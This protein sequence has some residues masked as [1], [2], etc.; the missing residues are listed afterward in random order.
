MKEKK[1]KLLLRTCSHS[2][3]TEQV[4][5]V[6]WTKILIVWQKE[7]TLLSQHPKTRELAASVYACFWKPASNHACMDT[8]AFPEASKAFGVYVPVLSSLL[9]PFQSC[10]PMNSDMSFT[11]LK[12]VWAFKQERVLAFWFPRPHGKCVCRCLMEDHDINLLKHSIFPPH[13]WDSCYHLVEIWEHL[14]KQVA[15]RKSSSKV[16][17]FIPK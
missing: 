14:R 13:G 1:K 17:V 6:W 9:T 2:S 5:T 11:S 16:A 15:A 8:E 7:E 10:L 12:W 4:L 3:D